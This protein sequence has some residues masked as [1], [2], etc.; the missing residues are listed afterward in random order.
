MLSNVFQYIFFLF[1]DVRFV[2]F[3]IS[4]ASYGQLFS[5]K[6]DIKGYSYNNFHRVT[7][8]EICSSMCLKKPK[9]SCVWVLHAQLY[10]FLLYL[11][12]FTSYAPCIFFDVQKHN[13][14]FIRIWICI[15][16]NIKNNS[17]K[18]YKNNHLRISFF[19]VSF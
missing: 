7:A 8:D 11:F 12:Y 10:Y 9:E 3:Q 16:K 19:S 1:L 17:I 2:C 14:W 15:I 4:L 13:Y 6:N 18:L 5:N